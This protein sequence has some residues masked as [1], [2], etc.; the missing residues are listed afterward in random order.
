MSF[1]QNLVVPALTHLELTD[2]SYRPR[3]V[4]VEHLCMMLEQS[5][6]NLTHLTI[7]G[8]L[9]EGPNELV[10]L[11][12]C[13]SS[14]TSLEL[15]DHYLIDD[16]CT[17]RPVLILLIVPQHSGEQGLRV[18]NI[19]DEDTPSHSDED[20]DCDLKPQVLDY[21]Q[22]PGEQC[23]LPR[24][25][26]FSL[27]VR[28]HC[29]T[30][31]TLLKV[32]HS[33]CIRPETASSSGNYQFVVPDTEQ[34]CVCLKKLRVKSTFVTGLPTQVRIVERFGRVQKRRYGY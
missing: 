29:K 11:L 27:T 25:K 9:A 10:H 28:P 13:V 7:R 31:R 14:V 3:V 17:I 4:N 6:S 20:S 23:L 19:S 8:I 18:G 24:L 22:T 12:Q 16:A 2:H 33:R 1:I 30:L 15:E 21:Y 5:H 32:V 34:M 26:Y